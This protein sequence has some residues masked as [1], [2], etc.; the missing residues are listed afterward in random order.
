MPA[1][2]SPY[3]SL[4]LTLL[5]LAALVG[6]ACRDG[7]VDGDGDS[8]VDG[9]GDSDADTDAEADGDGDDDGSPSG[10]EPALGGPCDPVDQC[11]CEAGQ[12]CALVVADGAV[13]EG[14]AEGPGGSAGHGDDCSAAECA[15]GHICLQDGTGAAACLRLCT[16]HTDCPERSLCD[17]GFTM[18]ELDPAP[19][20][21]CSPQRA[22]AEATW[23]VC[24]DSPGDC[25]GGGTE[26]REL[27]AASADWS[28]TLE[29][30]DEEIT[31][32]F[33]ISQGDTAVRGD[34]LTFP[35]AP[36]RLVPVSC[37]DFSVTDGGTEFIPG[38]CIA[39]A[40][41]TAGQCTIFVEYNNG[42]VTGNFRCVEIAGSGTD[43]V[44]TTMNGEEPGAGSF[45]LRVCEVTEL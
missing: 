40:M 5:A 43:E 26:V 17:V 44:L 35:N 34:G 31:L 30:S 18:S 25:P 16:E 33:E 13:V 7:E 42:Q 23:G 19:Y 6:P 10:C 36:T 2:W 21:A 39:G 37:G 12:S 4:T 29:V 3:F 15:A 20:R 14:C 32:S 11:G 28:C 9:D 45:A 27:D 38:E 41:P 22:E 1:G 8:D 24:I